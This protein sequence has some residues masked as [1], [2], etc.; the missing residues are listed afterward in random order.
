[1]SNKVLEFDEKL[2]TLEEENDESYSD[3]SLIQELEDQVKILNE[4]NKA[5][6]LTYA[7]LTRKSLDYLKKIKELKEDKRKNILMLAQENEKYEK[8][9]KMGKEHG[10]MT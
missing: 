6:N 8:M 4:R 2:K 3:D 1:M 7:Q 10:G 9:L 5:L